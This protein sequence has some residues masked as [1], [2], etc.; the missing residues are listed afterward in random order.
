[1]ANPFAIVRKGESLNFV[2]DRDGESIDGWICTISVKTFPADTSA[3]SPRVITP[4]G[5]T[6]PGFLTSTETDTLAIGD[7]RLIGLLTNATTNEEEQ[8]TEFN[9]FNVTEA[10]A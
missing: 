10:W 2:F 7:Y 4:V 1:M 5:R 3:I 9:R 6:W 8:E